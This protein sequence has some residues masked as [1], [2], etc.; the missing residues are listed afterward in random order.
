M[1]IILGLAGEIAS[2]KGTIAKY[3]C[4]KYDGGSHRFSTML[5]DVARR[6][7][8]EESRE[9]LQK[10]STIFRENFFDD[11]LSSVI[12]KDVEND[13]HNII[14]ID[15]VRRLADIKFLKK[16]PGFKLIYIEADIKNRYGRIINRGENSDDKSKT[17]EEFEKDHQREA[18]RQIKDLKKYASFVVNNNGSCEDLYKQID[19]IIKNN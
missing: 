10:I 1:K 12:A 17:F 5:R 7:Y 13:E 16:L 19:G 18:E 15:G 2:G 8:L 4:E 6:M 9:N 3:I 14:A 11:I